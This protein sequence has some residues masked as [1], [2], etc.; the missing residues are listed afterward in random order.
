MHE[1]H[2]FYTRR[3]C[4]A[5]VNAIYLLSPVEVQVAEIAGEPPVLAGFA[6]HV[7][8]EMVWLYVSK[9]FRGKGIARMLKA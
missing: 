6:A 3:Q 4:H 7:D 1:K 8:G 5:M 2:P 9:D